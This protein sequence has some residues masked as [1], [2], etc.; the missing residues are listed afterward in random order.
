MSEAAH[1]SAADGLAGT[2]GWSWTLALLYCSGFILV[3][4]GF[5][6]YTS[7]VDPDVAR[8]TGAGSPQSQAILAF[9]YLT[10]FLLLSANRQAAH[11]LRITWPILLL[12]ALACLS[13]LWSPDPALTLRRAIAFSGT[14]FFGLSLGAA[15]RFR[16]AVAL[17]S[18]ALTFVMALCIL[19]VFLDPV[20]AIHQ[21]NDAI[22]AVHA[23]FWRGIFAHRNTLGFWAGASIVILA[24]S[25]WTVR[26][27][28]WLRW[29][30]MA[31]AAV[32][33]LASG[34][35]A[36]LTIVVLS[37]IY[38]VIVISIMRREAHQ[39]VVAG[40]AWMTGGLLGYLFFN[41]IARTGLRLLGRDSDLTGRTELW[42][43]IVDLVAA[44]DRPMGL[45]YFVGTL[46]LDQ[47]LQSATQIRN[48]NAHNGF[49]E[50]YVYFG[51]PGALLALVVAVWLLVTTMR[52]ALRMGERIGSAAALPAVMVF[53]ALAHNL[54]ESTLV[55]PNNLN[56]VLLATAAAMVARTY[57]V[58]RPTSHIPDEL[59]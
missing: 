40:A 21:T 3:G 53:A 39:R 56:N 15:Y 12:P 25:G 58:T 17:V 30:G 5:V 57:P 49:L 7:S 43:Y 8:E 47:R 22:Q 14:I 18:F 32:C 50:S 16:D 27:G 2:G 24:A 29:S 55:S 46:L 23:G 52:F 1:S 6:L 34:S 13:I 59:A 36:G 44:A 42:A 41:E 38:Y 28:R 48:V 9:Y 20:M 26:T 35:S 45:G 10:A 19:L 51:W 37:A 31:A 33:L 11:V 54:V 4:G